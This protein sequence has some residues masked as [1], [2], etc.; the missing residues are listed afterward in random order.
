MILVGDIGGTNTRLAYVEPA[1]DRLRIV[2]E[3]RY[4]SAHYANLVGILAEF[5]ARYPLSCAS[6]CFGVPG[7]IT[8]GRC[9]TTNLPWIVDTEALRTQLKI[10]DIWLLNDLETIAYGI[11]TLPTS[12]LVP[13][14]P[15]AADR[16]GNAAVI[17]AGTGLG[18]AG[19]FWDGTRHRPFA[20]EGGHV[21]FAPSNE[22]EADL[23]A[24]LRRHFEHVSVERVLSGPGLVNIFQFLRDSGHADEPA[25]LRDSMQA[26]D[27]AEVITE[28]ALTKGAILC[29]QTL[30]VF[31]SIYGAETGNLALKTLASAGVYLA[32]GIAPRILPALQRAQFRAAF[33]NKGRMRAL[34][35]TVPVWVIRDDSTVG[36]L[37]AAQ[38]A[39]IRR[40]SG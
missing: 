15:G 36:L 26:R 19:L 4:G 28:T 3:A 10:A 12:Q 9:V 40:E 1:G 33:L 5:V 35:E 16:H 18:Q 14:N 8:D 24:Y 20:T 30:D 29:E 23:L 34:L 31:V 38:A 37:G 27:P 2:V 22:L 13:L 17:A 25:W 39:L 7:P 21:D 6:A 32:G 11:S